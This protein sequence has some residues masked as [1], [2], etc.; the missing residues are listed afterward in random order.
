MEINKCY[1][2]APTLPEMGKAGEMGWD[3]QMLGVGLHAG[4]HLGL[5]E[6]LR[7]I[8]RRLELPQLA[9]ASLCSSAEHQLL[10]WFTRASAPRSMLPTRLR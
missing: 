1:R 6:L 7:G 10:L 9:G 4:N 2:S 5:P 3:P 8:R